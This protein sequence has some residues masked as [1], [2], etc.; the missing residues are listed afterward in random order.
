[1]KA[2]K[3]QPTN[4]EANLEMKRIKEARAQSKNRGGFLKGLFSKK[5]K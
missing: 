1:V 2:L 5:K 3:I 4:P